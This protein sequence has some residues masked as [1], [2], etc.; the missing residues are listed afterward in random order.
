MTIN[1]QYSS[2]RKTF[3]ISTT[4]YYP[5]GYP[6]ANRSTNIGEYRY[7]FN[8]QEAERHHIRQQGFQKFMYL[9]IL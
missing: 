6:I 7:F 8:G 9:C 2:I 5:F 4:N 3:I 1:H